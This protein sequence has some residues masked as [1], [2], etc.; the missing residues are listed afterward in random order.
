MTPSAR[1]NMEENQEYDK[2]QYI[3]TLDNFDEHDTEV[4]DG[5]NVQGTQTPGE[6][7]EKGTEVPGEL[8]A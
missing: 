8:G 6:L 1:E 7:D 2:A 5:L 4:P 3:E